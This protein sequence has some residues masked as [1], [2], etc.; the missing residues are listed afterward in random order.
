M[1]SRIVDSPRGRLRRLAFSAAVIGGA[2]ATVGAFTSP[3]LANPATTKSTTKTYTIS[4]SAGIVGT[5]SETVTATNTYPTSVLHG[6]TF[7]INWHSITKVSKTQDEAAWS[8][9]ARSFKGKVTT[10]DYL[11]SDAT[12]NTVNVAG[13]S[14]IPTGG[15]LIG[16]PNYGTPSIYTPLQG[17]PPAVTPA[18]KAGVH[19]TDNVKPGVDDATLTLYSGPNGTGTAIATVTANCSAPSGTVYIASVPVS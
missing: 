4:C 10:I 18:F 9:G 1:L 13:A 17:Q 14:G 12:P 3:A 19:G 11:S 2:V 15:N 16:P 5:G 7:K 8:L 6:S